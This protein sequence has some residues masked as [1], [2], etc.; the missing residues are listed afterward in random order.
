MSGLLK[1]EPAQSQLIVR[2]HENRVYA[3][4]GFI[5]PPHR[6]ERDGKG[7]L[8]IG[9]MKMK[10]EVIARQDAFQAERGPAGN[11]EIQDPSVPDQSSLFVARARTFHDKPRTYRLIH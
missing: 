1:H 6:R 5:N 10:F 3:A 9:K 11:G 4:A 8:V 7:G 2:I